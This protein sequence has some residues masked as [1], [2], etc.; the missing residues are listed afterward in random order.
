MSLAQVSTATFEQNVLQ[1]DLPTLCKYT[2][3]WCLYCVRQTPVLEAVA[4]DLS[5]TCSVV[6]LDIDDSPEIAKQYG[7][8]SIPTLILFANGKEVARQVGSASKA[9]IVEMVR[10]ALVDIAENPSDADILEEN[11]QG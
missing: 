8:R 5:G 10:E 3:P 4:K 11:A 1:A 9:A 7:V 2:A 6:E